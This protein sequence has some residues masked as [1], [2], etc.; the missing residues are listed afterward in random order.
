MDVPT[1]C[2]E[3]DT[4]NKVIMTVLICVV[5]SGSVLNIIM[6]R[7]W[8]KL[9]RERRPDGIYLQIAT[10]R[11]AETIHV[12]ECHMPLDQIFQKSKKE[13]LLR[14]ITV[15]STWGKDEVNI[16]WGRTVYTTDVVHYG[17]VTT[18]VLP[19][20]LLISH[21][22]AGELNGSYNHT[23]MARLVRYIGGLASVVPVDIPM[24]STSGWSA[25]GD[26][27]WSLQDGRAMTR[28]STPKIARVR[29]KT[30]PGKPT[31]SLSRPVE[32]LTPRASG[33]GETGNRREEAETR[34]KELSPLYE[35]C[36][37]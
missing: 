24:I 35:E 18:V 4:Q 11:M 12:G 27:E 14:E 15:T 16:V 33:S 1:E 20:H 34:R 31:K 28:L 26:G 5:L 19:D 29:G 25:V 6:C 22:M 37:V 32:N 23:K 3:V 30:V 2:H 21:E 17:E 13:P 8:R 10:D 7:K 9:A 36:F